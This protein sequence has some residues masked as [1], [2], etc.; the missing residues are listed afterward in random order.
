MNDKR[1]TVVF[2]HG[3]ESSPQSRKIIALTATA[4]G[5]GYDVLAVDYRGIDSPKERVTRLVDAC[6]DVQGDLVLVG[7][8]LGGYVSLVGAPTLHARGVFLM[9]PAIYFDQL[10]PLRERSIDCPF[11][12]VHGWRDDV[13]PYEDS[14]RLARE[15]R[16]T[17]H[18]VDSDHHLYTHMRMIRYYFEHFLIGLDLP[19]DLQ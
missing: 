5:E 1:G 2:S 4:Q 6:K 18:L 10:P 12:I 3:L 13:V 15:Y 8:S 16:A 17:L 19:R 9:A 14:L 7:S 11:T